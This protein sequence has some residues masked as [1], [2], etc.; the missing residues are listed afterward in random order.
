ML[1]LADLLLEGKG[2]KKNRD[3]AVSL[4]RRAARAGSDY[5]KEALEKLNLGW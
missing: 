4:Y 3:E 5:S 1:I 2:M